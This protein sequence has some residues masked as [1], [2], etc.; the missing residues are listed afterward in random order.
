MEEDAAENIAPTIQDPVFQQPE[1][2]LS[3]NPHRVSSLPVEAG[4]RPG[5]LWRN[6]KW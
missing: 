5:N 2:D 6:A 4:P 1:V 3:R